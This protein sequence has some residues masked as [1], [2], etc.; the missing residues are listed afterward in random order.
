MRSRAK[1]SGSVHGRNLIRILM[2]VD[3]LSRPQ[4]A[5]I[6]DLQDKLGVA[7]R[8]VYRL[9]DTLGELQFPIYDEDR[10][11]EKEKRWHLQQDYLQSLPNLRIPDMKFSPRELLVLYFLLSQDRVFANTAVVGL[12]SSI[13]EKLAALMPSRYLT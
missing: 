12:L 9:F 1:Y 5:T 11:G 6:K 2:A 8:S 10:P 4:G 13:R 7:R 3:V